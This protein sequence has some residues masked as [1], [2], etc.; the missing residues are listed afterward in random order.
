M[1]PS[2][3][4][5]SL[6][7]PLL[8]SASP[9]N[10]TKELELRSNGADGTKSASDIWWRWVDNV[11]DPGNYFLSAWGGHMKEYKYYTSDHKTGDA[12]PFYPNN[13]PQG[14]A[15]DEQVTWVIGNINL[16]GQ[17]RA[18]LVSY[19]HAT[20]C[21]HYDK[22]D[23]DCTNQPGDWGK[24]R[25]FSEVMV[26][27]KNADES[28]WVIGTVH[29]PASGQA[30]YYRCVTGSGKQITAEAKL[31]A[32]IGAVMGYDFSGTPCNRYQRANGGDFDNPTG[33][34]Y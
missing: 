2:V 5:S 30:D 13:M 24:G 27:M 23:G 1:K 7:L 8:A 15:K 18:S 34:L 4:L 28:Y 19:S 6:L 31:T 21:V 26:P 16:N 25:Q 29:Y 22:V 3:A 17:G 10:A 33:N 14:M 11:A 9:I 12:Q 32:N 20:S